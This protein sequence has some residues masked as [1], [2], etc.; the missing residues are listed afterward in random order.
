MGQAVKQILVVE[1]EPEIAAA[2]I[3]LLEAFGFSVEC[4]SRGSHGLEALEHNPPDIL[5][6]DMTLPDMDGY[7]ILRAVRRKER[8]NAG[9]PRLP[10]LVMTGRGLP[11]QVLCESEG[12]DGFIQ[13]PFG[14]GELLDALA[15]VLQK[16]SETI[17]KFGL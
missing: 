10:I 12:I 13:K 14:H 15:K 2:L 5:L 11:T 17:E 1:D 7:H 3:E 4:T 8:Q 9:R 16:N 6:L